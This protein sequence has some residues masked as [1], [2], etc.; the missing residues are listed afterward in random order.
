MEIKFSQNVGENNIRDAISGIDVGAVEIKR[1][2]NQ[3]YILRFK[4][5]N[6]ETHRRLIQSFERIGEV[7]ELRFDSIGPIIGKE[8]K[9]KAILAIIIALILMI[10]YLAFAF[11]QVS[12]IFSS[13][14][15]GLVT[16]LT[17]IFDI[18][19]VLG[20]FSYL[21]KYNQVEIGLPFIAAIL[22]VIG[23]SINDRIIIFDRLREN[24]INSKGQDFSEVVGKSLSQSYTRSFNTSF[25]TI[26]VLIPIIIF[27]G[28]SIKYFALTLALGIAFG[29]Y[30]SI[31]LA[32]PI[33]MDFKKLFRE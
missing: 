32:A 6:Q 13:W 20:I 31:F 4:E 26:L 24:L 27:G 29:T 8:L 30:S 16:I 21:G 19:L 18:I 1:G 2:E 10:I 28:E 5:I 9:N 12:Y 14:S 23:Y 22:A 25:T 33:L 11:R 3:S 17:L 15:Y 7:K